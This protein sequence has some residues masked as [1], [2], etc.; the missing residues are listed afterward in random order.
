MG[1]FDFFRKFRA[2]EAPKAPER[3]PVAGLAPKHEPIQKPPELSEPGPESLSA[4]ELSE[5]MKYLEPLIISVDRELAEIPVASRSVG[6]FIVCV[7]DDSVRLFGILYLGLEHK[8]SELAEDIKHMSFHLI[9]SSL[10][11]EYLDGFGLVLGGGELRIDREAKKITAQGFS[12][13]YGRPPKA[14]VQKALAL[15]G[16]SVQVVMG[17]SASPDP[18]DNPSA[19]EWFKKR[20]VETGD[21]WST[22]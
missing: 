1:L 5:R 17:E 14:M 8:R 7:K 2:S 13:T 6:K 11:K 4:R 20:G 9:L 22:E 12:G 19:V 15:D 16:Y 18:H 21:P 3:D 10:N